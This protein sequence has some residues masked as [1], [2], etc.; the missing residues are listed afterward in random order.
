[1]RIEYTNYD[2]D[3]HELCTFCGKPQSDHQVIIGEHEGVRYVHRQPCPEQQHEIRKR[4]VLEGFVRRSIVLMV[5]VCIYIRDRIPFKKEMKLVWD[6]IVYVF[7]TARALLYL[8][9]TKPKQ[10]EDQKNNN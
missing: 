5:N 7:I 4:A 2:G 8:N 6:F 10:S 1:M 3:W 9:K